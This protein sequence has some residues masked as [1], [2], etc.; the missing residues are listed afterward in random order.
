[1]PVLHTISG[2]FRVRHHFWLFCI[3]FISFPSSISTLFIGRFFGSFKNQPS[4]TAIQSSSRNVSLIKRLRENQRTLSRKNLNQIISS[5]KN[6]RTC[7]YYVSRAKK[8]QN[9]NDYSSGPISKCN[10][11]EEIY[12]KTA[13]QLTQFFWRRSGGLIS[14]FSKASRTSNR[15]SKKEVENIWQDTWIWLWS[16][17]RLIIV[18][19]QGRDLFSVYVLRVSAYFPAPGCRRATIA[20]MYTHNV[21]ILAGCEGRRPRRDRKMDAVQ[22]SYGVK[23]W[24]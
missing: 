20:E 12:R 14:I 7:G 15:V 5:M 24:H 8:V 2:L 13:L 17:A 6:A 22:L 3:Q 10:V 9:C 23:K 4:F 16:Q 1:M 21:Y 18:L 11:W 19:Q